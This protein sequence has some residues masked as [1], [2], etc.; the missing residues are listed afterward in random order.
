MLPMMNMQQKPMTKND[1]TVIM[2]IAGFLVCK[3][4]RK[5]KLKPQK[6]DS[7]MSA[8]ALEPS[9]TFTKEYQSFTKKQDRG[10]LVYVKDNF[11]F[12]VR[13]IEKIYREATTSKPLHASSLLVQLDR[14]LHVCGDRGSKRPGDFRKVKVST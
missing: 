9:A 12:M 2:H 8:R 1:Q 10:G 11:F 14:H 5:Y 4:T 3:L 7:I 6:K 13:E